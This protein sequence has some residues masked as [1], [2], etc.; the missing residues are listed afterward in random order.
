MIVNR[1]LKPLR[2][3]IRAYWEQ[4]LDTV[5]MAQRDADEKFQTTM[6]LSGARRTGP[7]PADPNDTR[8]L[9]ICFA[10]GYV[11]SASSVNT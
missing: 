8:V 5:A 7:V 11:P 3:Q 6:M 9:R 1:E 4:G 2:Q 10:T